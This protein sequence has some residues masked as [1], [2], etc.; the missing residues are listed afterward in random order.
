MK[1]LKVIFVSLFLFVASSA[2]ADT[3]VKIALKN[4]NGSKFHEE[5]TATGLPVVSLTWAGFEKVTGSVRLYQPKAARSLVGVMVSNGVRTED[6]ADPGEL[7]FATSRALTA[8]ESTALDAAI[9]AHVSSVLTAEQTRENQDEADWTQFIADFG[10]WDAM[11]TAQ[12]MAF[13]KRAMR[14]LLR[15]QRG[16]AL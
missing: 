8:L 12:R 11:N 10:T 7:R 2:F 6:F 9:T 13:L 1:T 15:A 14:V 16:A 5:I 4:F 3:V